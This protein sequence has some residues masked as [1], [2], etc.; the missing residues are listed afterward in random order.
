MPLHT[1]QSAYEVG[2]AMP[3]QKR[4]QDADHLDYL[5]KLLSQEEA[6][7]GKR[8]FKHGK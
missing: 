2:I 8:V 3:L 7:T 4:S 1:K 6:R 5:D